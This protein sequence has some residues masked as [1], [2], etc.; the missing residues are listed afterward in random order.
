MDWGSGNLLPVGHRVDWPLESGTAFL[1]HG[2]FGSC[3]LP[4][5]AYQKELRD[6]L[7]RQPV[8]FFVRDLESMWDEALSR[9]AEFLNTDFEQLAFVSSATHGVNAV[10]RSLKFG[11]GDELLV[12]DHEYNAC[13]N[14]LNFVAEKS[15]AK[16]NVAKLKIPVYQPTDWVSTILEKV[17]PRTK[18]LLIDHVT[19]PT[20]VVMPLE[21][22]ISEMKSRGI[23]VLVDGAHAPGMIPLN[24]D[25][26]GADFYTGN[27]HKWLCSPKGAGFL[28]VRKD[29]QNRIRPLAISHGA[30]STRTDRSRFHLEF[31]WTGT[32]DPTACLSVPVVIDWMEQQM[33]GGWESIMKRNNHLAILAQSYLNKQLAWKPVA[34]STM[35][36]S[37]AALEMP[38]STE[39][40]RPTSPLYSDPFQDRLWER[41]QVEVP[42]VPWPAPPKRLIRISAQLYNQP[43]DYVQLLHA[44]KASKSEWGE[45]QKILSLSSQKD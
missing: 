27:C 37:M 3:P 30:N 5:L 42:I 1:N 40:T 43:E 32:S 44:I 38:D 25:Q 8:Q 20:A 17:T 13:H 35:I 15:G 2:S 34:P 39:V 9:L 36:G 28:F 26:L 12:T 11:T 45:S 4:V 16:V 31:G 21:E 19:S 7:E 23:L 22:I 6:R 14:A 10:L 18:L 24:L 29:L 33:P 41:Y